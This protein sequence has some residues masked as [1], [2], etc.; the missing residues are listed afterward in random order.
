MTGYRERACGLPTANKLWFAPANLPLVFLR[1]SKPYSQPMHSILNFCN[2]T[3]AFFY[4]HFNSWARL[5]SQ[6]DNA[7][8]LV[9]GAAQQP[10]SMREE[11]CL[12]LKV[13]SLIFSS[14]SLHSPSTLPCTNKFPLQHPA[15]IL[16]SLQLFPS[17]CHSASVQGLV[18]QHHPGY[19]RLE[20]KCI[21]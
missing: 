6:E 3:S 1:I 4:I 5:P 9:D 18:F 17:I 14:S 21:G 12:L 13:L 7:Y 11:D 20:V 15:R 8:C 19:G 2:S 10:P 16:H